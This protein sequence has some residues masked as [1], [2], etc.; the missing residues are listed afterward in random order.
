MYDD[1]DFDQI[2]TAEFREAFNEF[3]KVSSG[4]SKKCNGKCRQ[5][6]LSSFIQFLPNTKICIIF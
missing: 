1:E 4:D 6:F 2:Q 3:D 5:N